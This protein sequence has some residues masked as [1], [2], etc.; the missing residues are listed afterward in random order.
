M[1]ILMLSWEYPPKNIGGLST[2]VYNL[3]HALSALD[4]EV[5]VITCE[6]GIAP[7]EEVDNGVFV[8]RVTPYKIQTDDFTKWVMQLNFAIIEEAV[9]LIRKLGN[10]DMIH[11]H[12]WLS[13]YSAKAL[14]WSYNIPMVCTMHATETGRNNGIRTEMQRYIS[15]VEW[16]L[17]YEAWKVIACSN[18]MKQQIVGTFSTPE[19][20]VWII[21]NGVNPRLFSF[22][23]DWLSFRRQY[24]MDDEKIVFFVGRHVFEKGVQLLIEAAPKIVAGYNKTKFVIAGKG[25]MTE[26]LKARVRSMGLESKVLFVGYMDDESRNKLYRVS[27]AAVFPSLYEPF[28]IVAL[29]AMAA[30][31]PVVVSDTGGL[32]ELIKH[33]ENGMKMING[34]TDSL[35]DNVLQLLY[36]DGLANYIKE[37]GAK[38]VN[39]NYTWDRVAKLTLKMYDQIREEAAGTEWDTSVDLFKS[40]EAF[41]S[42]DKKEETNEPVV[43][44]NN[45]KVE[46]EIIQPVEEKADTIEEKEAVIISPSA[47]KFIEEKVVKEAPKA[48]EEAEEVVEEAPKAAEEAEEVV[49]EAPKAAEK[50]EKIVEETSKPEKSVQVQLEKTQNS[51]SSQE[52][53]KENVSEE[54]AIDKPVEENT[55]IEVEAV[56]KNRRARKTTAASKQTT[57]RSSRTKSKK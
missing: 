17:T 5:H 34:L 49:E 28:G 26:E 14:K 12:D 18:Y 22:D 11:A 33:R 56:T 53:K 35:K 39:E 7:I 41:V 9:R 31:C 2:H 52:T 25:P 21:P 57:A 48:I 6:E 1:R 27:N 13:A 20:K 44:E 19:E 47:D 37:N 45:N 55:K 51:I 24:A 4:H 54:I 36:D 50:V 8:H 23:F 46:N 32:S 30:G 38:T 43:L 16:T 10:V 42:E 29:E 3:S 15:N 40:K